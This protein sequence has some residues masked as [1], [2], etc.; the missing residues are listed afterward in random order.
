MQISSPA[1]RE[2]ICRPA[3]LENVEG[4]KKQ[5]G[6][7]LPEKWVRVREASKPSEM[8]RQRSLQA[9]SWSPRRQRA[10]KS[11]TMR[12]AEGGC[13]RCAGRGT[14]AKSKDGR[15]QATPGAVN[16]STDATDNRSG[17]LEEERR[18]TDKQIKVTIDNMIA[19]EEWGRR[20]SHE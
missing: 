18:R 11:D 10:P 17:G 13:V 6:T 16:S 3:S 20:D 1:K 15:T 4:G 5:H 14:E 9:S 7:I 2:Q 12:D 19:S 8:T